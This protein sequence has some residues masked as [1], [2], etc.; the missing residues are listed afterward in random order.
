MIVG[1]SVGGPIMVVPEC[2][3]DVLSLGVGLLKTLWLLIM[4]E[5]SMGHLAPWRILLCLHC[6]N[7]C[8]CS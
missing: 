1:F 8:V 2:D 7:V 6:A 4:I 5:C 3:C